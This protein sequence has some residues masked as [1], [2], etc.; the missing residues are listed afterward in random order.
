MSFEL[1][2]R[3]KLIC[4]AECRIDL[5]TWKDWWAVH[6][7]EV[8]K[9]VSPG[10]F[11]RLNCAPS[12]YGPDTFMVKCQKGAEQYLAKMQISFCHSDVYSK[13]AEKEYKLYHEN[14]EQRF[15]I[16][17]EEKQRLYRQRER[18]R[19]ELLDYK[20]PAGNRTK[21]GLRT[22]PASAGELEIIKLLIEWTEF[23]AQEK[24]KEALDMF[25]LDEHNESHWTPELLESAIYTYGCPGYT[26]EQAEEEF[27][28]ADYK[29]TS[30]LE[31][32]DK[33]K[34][35]A[36]IDISSDYSWMGR[37][38]T[39]VIHYDHVPLNGKMSDLTARFFLR[40]IDSNTVTLA[41][42]DLHV[43]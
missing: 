40:K 27:G 14:L 38:D 30:V 13:G 18:E 23:L 11:S 21:S 17:Q 29:V 10:D 9:I 16:Q 19:R 1:E 15:R 28:S 4:L 7:P 26:R 36:G 8:K 32:P 43:M 25:L 33:D 39:A 37:N 31:N 22:L 12:L 20:I 41:F 6:S 35:I 2:F 3:D 5:V 34:I 42:I 24:Y